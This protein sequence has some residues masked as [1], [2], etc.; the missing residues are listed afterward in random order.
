MANA[1]AI[2]E[3][4]AAWF[5][6]RDGADWTAADQAE[7]EAWVN[8]ATAH[9]VAFIRVEAAWAEADRLKAL[10]A[11]VAAGDVPAPGRWRL[12]P[13]FSPAP[14]A[15]ARASWRGA[16]AAGI[17]VVI[18]AGVAFALLSDRGDSYRTAVGGLETVPLADGS[19][20][21]LNTDSAMTVA[22]D[23]GARTIRLKQGEAF[24]EVAKDPKRPFVVDT[25]KAR[26]IAVGTKFSV[27]H[28]GGDIQVAVT[29]G[30]VRI[31]AVDTPEAP[32]AQLDAGDVARTATGATLVAVR[33][34]PAVEEELLSWRRGYVVFRAT[35]LAEAVQEF[36][37]YNTRKIMI[38]DAKVGAI[39]VGGSFQ[40][41]NIDAFVRLLE[42]GFT[43]RASK[44]GGG[45]IVLSAN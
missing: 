29:E 28:A 9:R 23:E 20:V 18:A 12:S 10:G 40:V 1:K 31:E 39:R 42:D 32:A 7:L 41:G 19:K 27:R 36:N 5:A 15:S 25:G 6:R 14:G 38:A 37:R 43:V 3:A 13:F 16:M 30:R 22:L 26:V 2:D 4:A 33:T 45:D 34:L 35:P 24:F 44:N 11:G 17:A 8:A 21:T